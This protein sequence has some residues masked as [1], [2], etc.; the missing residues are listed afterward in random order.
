MENLYSYILGGLI[1]KIWGFSKWTKTSLILEEL[2]CH[3]SSHLYFVPSHYFIISKVLFY[4]FEDKY[5][6]DKI[7]NNKRYS[8][9]YFESQNL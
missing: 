1:F 5:V 2:T 7:L 3:P 9:K 4:K 6:I 8:A